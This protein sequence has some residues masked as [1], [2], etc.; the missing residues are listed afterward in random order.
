[1]VQTA[2]GVCTSMNNYIYRYFD[3]ETGNF[4]GVL[5]KMKRQSWGRRQQTRIK[6]RKLLPT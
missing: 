3:L 4:L 1:M 6:K 5:V 2:F